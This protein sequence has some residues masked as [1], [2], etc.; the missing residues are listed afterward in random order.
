VS[1][2][3]L[4]PRFKRLESRL[5]G[6]ILVEPVVHGDAR[7]FLLESYRRSAMAELGI[8]EEFV[9]DNH[10]RSR[11]GI[12]RGMHFQTGEPQAKLVQ[13]VRGS[14]FDVVVDVRR[15]SPSFASWEGFELSD[16]NHRQL[17]VPNG[18][19][20][21]FCVVSELADVVYKL[22]SYYDATVDRGIRYDDPD[23]GVKWPLEDLLPSDR[24]ANAPA[25][26]EIAEELP[27]SY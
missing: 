6:P 15:G 8:H 11:R 10:S 1:G 20:H 25:L 22:S 7:G 5:E 13:C 9:Q 27:F 19:A 21:G 24:D 18:F 26:R 17:Y 12:V 2:P 3:V 16:E 4:S 14:V 23:V